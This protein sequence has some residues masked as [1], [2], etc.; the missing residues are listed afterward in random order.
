MSA[1]N[2]PVPDLALGPDRV[3]GLAL[4][5]RRVADPGRAAGFELGSDQA[6][7][8]DRVDRPTF[9]ALDFVR[10]PFGSVPPEWEAMRQP[11]ER[12]EPDS[13]DSFPRKRSNWRY[14]WRSPF[15]SSYPAP[16][17]WP[18]HR[19][20]PHRSR[21]CS[22]RG[23]SWPCRR[24]R[25]RPFDPKWP[26]PDGSVARRPRRNRFPVVCRRHLRVVFGHRGSVGPDRPSSAAHRAIRF[27]PDRVI[28][29]LDHSTF[30]SP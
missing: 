25:A 16:P 24:D 28:A 30:A 8:L 26:W 13:R 27:W 14:P 22:H 21:P 19:A 18:K 11:V 10:A 15:R 5:A 12:G 7:D 23:R 4:F 6:V 1:T 29:G 2:Y 3:A 9:P 20:F 17:D